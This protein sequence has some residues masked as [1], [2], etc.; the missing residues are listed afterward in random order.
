MLPWLQVET[1]YIRTWSVD[2]TVGA[3]TD[4]Y[5]STPS[6]TNAVDALDDLLAWLN[7]FAR[8]WYGVVYFAARWDSTSTAKAEPVVYLTGAGT[9]DWTPDTAATAAMGW[10]TLAGVS[11]TTSSGLAGSWYPARGAYL[12]RW[13]RSLGNGP[14]AATGAL[15]PGQPGDAGQRGEIEALTDE[16]APYTLTQSLRAATLPRRGLIYNDLSGAWVDV[17]LGP[18][19]QERLQ[20][21][22]YRVRIT[23]LGG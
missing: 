5:S 15:R 3:D 4:T 9:F 19:A 20:P 18:V 21:R 6:L 10:D 23:V 17:A 13:L 2:V 7:S 16:L 11:E 8:A 22:V 14:A 12:R 1:G